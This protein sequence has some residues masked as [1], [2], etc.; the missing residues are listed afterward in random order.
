MDAYQRLRPNTEIQACDCA[1]VNGL[2]LVDLLT[3][4]PLHCE[5]CRKEVDPERLGLSVEEVES[6][7]SWFSVADALYRLWLDSGEYEI[8]AKRCLVDPKSQVNKDGLRVA[9]MLSAKIPT[10]LWF[11]SD[12]DDGIPSSCPVCSQRL[13]EE[14]KWG[15][16]RCPNCAIQL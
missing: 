7:A 3:D 16:G 11:F 12:T 6:V 5:F 13:D 15:S 10:R 4:N 8:Y 9:N 2:L 14:V 1:T